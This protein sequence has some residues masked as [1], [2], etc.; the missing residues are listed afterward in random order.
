MFR[1]GDCLA[2][3][4][5]R[6]AGLDL[7]RTLAEADVAQPG[8]AEWDELRVGD[9]GVYEGEEDGLEDEEE[10]FFEWDVV[11]LADDTAFGV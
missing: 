10:V 11:Y 6:A 4:A 8:Y 1:H 5:G 9:D 3:F 2:L 7:R